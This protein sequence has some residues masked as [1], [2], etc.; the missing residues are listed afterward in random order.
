MPFYMVSFSFISLKGFS[1]IENCF[2]TFLSL[3]SL[4]KRCLAFLFWNDYGAKHPYPT[5]VAFCHSFLWCF[6]FSLLTAWRLRQ[7]YAKLCPNECIMLVDYLKIIDD[8]TLSNYFLELNRN[9]Y[10]LWSKFCKND[11]PYKSFV[12]Y[13]LLIL[14]LHLI[15]LKFYSTLGNMII[16]LTFESALSN[17]S[18]RIN[19]TG[20]WFLQCQ[21]CRSWF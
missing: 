18:N 15:Y 2:Y 11:R 21:I 17:S 20:L 16:I 13:K 19:K 14:W 10:G 12:P 9:L 8:L 6:T 5:S 1:T 7:L 4:L 3:V